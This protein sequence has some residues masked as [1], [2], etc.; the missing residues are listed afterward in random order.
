MPVRRSLSWSV[1]LC[2]AWTDGISPGRLASVSSFERRAP[3]VYLGAVPG[4]PAAAPVGTFSSVL[5][6]SRRMREAFGAFRRET[7]IPD[8]VE[9]SINASTAVDS[10]AR[11]LT[12]AI[13]TNTTPE[14]RIDMREVAAHVL[15]E[16]ARHQNPAKAPNP[17]TGRT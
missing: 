14:G 16:L 1:T 4:S 12:E 5:T 13:D 3:T 2:K 17:N 10:L 15:A 6:P 11:L 7:G 9:R 8:M